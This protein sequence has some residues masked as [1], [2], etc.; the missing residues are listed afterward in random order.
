MF[1]ST[2]TILIRNL[3]LPQIDRLVLYKADFDVN[4]E[5]GGKIV[6]KLFEP[7]LSMYL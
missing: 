7:T 3:L 4:A 5:G 1:Q 6:G 2:T